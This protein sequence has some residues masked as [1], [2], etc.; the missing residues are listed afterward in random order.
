MVFRKSPQLTAYL[1]VKYWVFSPKIRTKPRLTAFA[2]SILH[3]TGGY[4]QAI[5][6]VK[7]IKGIQ[8]GKKQN[9]ISRWHDL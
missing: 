6:Q 5:K 7:E 2:T 4:S 9:S 8:T 1:M 3:C